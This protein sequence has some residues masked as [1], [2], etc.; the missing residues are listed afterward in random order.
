MTSP[1]RETDGIAC[2]WILLVTNPRTGRAQLPLFT[3]DGAKESRA[4]LT[5]DPAEV[6]ELHWR[7]RALAGRTGR[8]VRLVRYTLAEVVEL[9]PAVRETDDADAHS[10]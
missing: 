2:L 6:E 10:R 9:A 4:L 3:P 8:Q 7:G 1:V 5:N